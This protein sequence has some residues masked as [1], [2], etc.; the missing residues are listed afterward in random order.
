MASRPSPRS[1]RPTATSIERV[2]RTIG[3]QIEGLDVP[4]VEKI[5]E[6]QQRDP[7]H[8]LIST[9]LSARTQD[10][11]TLAASTRL[12][13]KAPTPEAVARLS[14]TQ[15]EKLI[16]PVGFYRNKAAFVKDAAKMIA[17]RFGGKVPRTMEELVTI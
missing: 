10:A 14:T 9:L 15:I 11:T 12:F 5:S 16:Y 13:A 3:R 6:R 8:I 1:P 2:M 17:T 7:F 4:A